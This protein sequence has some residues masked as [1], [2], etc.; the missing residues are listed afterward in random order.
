MTPYIANSTLVDTPHPE[1]FFCP[2]KQTLY[3][4]PKGM[5]QFE[6][7]FAEALYYDV[8]LTIDEESDG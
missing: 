7:L 4:R 3:F 5:N 6:T 2:G 1:T 8:F